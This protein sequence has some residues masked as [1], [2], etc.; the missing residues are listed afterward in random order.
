MHA[1]ALKPLIACTLKLGPCKT[2][3]VEKSTLVDF[4]LPWDKNVMNKEDEKINNYSRS[5]NK[6]IPLL[7]DCLGVVYRRVP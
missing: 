2:V 7:V 1:A 5:I 4:S 3:S 6:V